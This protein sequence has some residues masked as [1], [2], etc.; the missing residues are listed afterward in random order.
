M[1][2]DTDSK[3]TYRQFPIDP[4]DYEYLGFQWDGFFFFLI[5]GA[6]SVCVHLS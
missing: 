5:L 1:D 6:P 4:K 3:R 2:Y